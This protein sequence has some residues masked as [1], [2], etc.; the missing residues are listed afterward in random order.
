MLVTPGVVVAPVVEVLGPEVVALVLL[1]VVPGVV[2]LGA[3]PGVVVVEM[4][5]SL[6]V[7]LVVSPPAVPAPLPFHTLPLLRRLMVSTCSLPCESKGPEISTCTSVPQYSWVPNHV[8]TS[9]L[10]RSDNRISMEYWLWPLG[11]VKMP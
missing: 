7:T 6:V 4:V 2:E 1:G 9:A 11:F 10:P 8:T 3:W 5:V